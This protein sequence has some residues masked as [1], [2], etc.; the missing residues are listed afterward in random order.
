MLEGSFLRHE[1]SL[2]NRLVLTEI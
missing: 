1:S 2:G